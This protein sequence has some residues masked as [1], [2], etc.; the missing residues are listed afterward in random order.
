MICPEPV[1]AVT[2][3]VGTRFVALAGVLAGAGHGVTLAIANDPAEAAAVPDGIRVVHASPDSLGAQADGHDWVLLHGHLGNHYLAQRDDLPVVVDLYDPFLVEN[4][5]YH[6]ELGFSPYRTDHATWRLQLGRGDL[7]LCSSPEQR[8]FYMG[9][10]GALG[11]VN[12][13][14]MEDDP[15]LERLITEL[16]FGTPDGPPPARASAGDVLPGVAEGAPVLYFGGIY[17]WYDPR[18]LL[19]ALPAI[20]EASPETVVVFVDHPH[21]EGTPL[22]VAANAKRIAEGRGWLGTTVRFEG[23]RPSD[24]RFE[25]ALAADLAVVTH[26]PGLETELSL[27]TRLVDLLWLGLPVVATEGGTM[28]RV[29]EK[30][31]AGRTVPAGDPAA[32]ADAVAAFLGDPGARAEAGEAGRAWA[33]GRSWSRVAA[34]LLEFAAAPRRDPHRDRFV[35]FGPPPSRAVEPLL[36]RL[37]R[38]LG[39]FGGRR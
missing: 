14:A 4:L 35:E 6:R 5:H 22:D 16:P 33:R 7:F 32:L 20:L 37:R 17:D 15:S 3:G 34:P 10:L 39:R 24:R 1:R 21:P 28:G 19:D 18:V 26:R 27:R 31:G 36:R 23:W 29:L 38:A 2:A 8:F 13:L 9:W 30:T 12:P 25:L 11:R